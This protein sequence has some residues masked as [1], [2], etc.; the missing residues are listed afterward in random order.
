[1][2]YMRVLNL[3]LAA[4]LTRNAKLQQSGELAENIDM[5][6]K[7]WSETFFRKTVTKDPISS[8]VEC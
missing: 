6:G 1:M 8:D 7:L 2:T 3:F 5:F 4:E